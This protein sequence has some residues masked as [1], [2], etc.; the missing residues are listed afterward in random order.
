[1]RSRSLLLP[2]T[3]RER[4]VHGWRKIQ[5]HDSETGDL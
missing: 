4:F 3:Q 1:M 5:E 2:L